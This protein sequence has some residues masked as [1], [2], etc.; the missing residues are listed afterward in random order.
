M[1]ADPMLDEYIS[2]RPCVCINWLLLLY[3]YNRRIC[4]KNWATQNPR[5]HSGRGFRH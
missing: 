1:T 4:I 2:Q 5:N 3:T